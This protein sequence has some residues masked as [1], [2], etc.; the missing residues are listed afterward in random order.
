MPQQQQQLDPDAVR[1]AK[2]IRK[3]ESNDNFRARG[4][5]GEFGAYQFTNDTWNQWSKQYL[6]RA[7][8]LESATREEQNEVAYKKIKELKD[9]GFNVGQIASSWNAGEG[10]KDA[11]LTGHSGVNDKGVAYDTGAYAKKVAENYQQM[12]QRETGGLGGNY[13]PPP[14]VSQEPVA[15]EAEEKQN[16]K[17]G[18]RKVAE[19]LFPILE[20][21]PR[22]AL[23]T[24]GDLGLSAL[25]L[26]PGLGIGGLGAKIAAKGAGAAIKGLIPAALRA[27]NIAKGAAIGY[28]ADVAS[29]LSQGETGAGVLTPG[30][31]TAVGGVGGG[32]LTLAKKAA[33]ALLSGASGIPKGVLQTGAERAPAVKGILKTGTTP[34]EARNVAVKAAQGVQKKMYSSWD[35]QVDK[36]VN[37]YSAKRVGL[38]QATAKELNDFAG[39]YNTSTNTRIA[40][41]QNL[42]NLSA[43]ELIELHTNLN[44]SK[45]R[46]LAVG[47]GEQHLLDDLKQYVRGL[48]TKNFDD[49]KEFTKLLETYSKNKKVLGNVEQVLQDLNAN[50]PKTITAGIKKLQ[51]VF[52]SGEEEFLEAIKMLEKESGKDI[53]SHIVANKVGPK[54][55]LDPGSILDFKDILRWLTV[56]GTSP[57]ATFYINN[58]LNGATQGVGT[59]AVKKAGALVP[60]V[61]GLL[62]R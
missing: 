31:G 52:N 20:D 29:N 61:P 47:R 33:P 26:V 55:N 42:N 3:I 6:G 54:L 41:P 32:A 1:L 38:P 14:S 27:S 25:T 51:K 16:N 39:R 15:S 36:I 17:S 45:L 30:L 10:R 44:S 24:V 60:V 8:P 7:T 12:K 23:Q 9:R 2:S 28:G 19:F 46:D 53:L 48:A 59:Q 11:Y 62:E 22:T 58:L 4:K 56:V 5:S 34:K 57:R 49:K 43:K 18:L 35:K 37:T 13:A 40:I 21:K 50:D